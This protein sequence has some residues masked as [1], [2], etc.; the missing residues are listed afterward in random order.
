VIACPD[1]PGADDCMRLVRQV[2]GGPGVPRQQ[3]TCVSPAGAVR[4]PA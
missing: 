3:G 1:P 2:G 4:A